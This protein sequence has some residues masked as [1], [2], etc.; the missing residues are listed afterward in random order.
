MIGLLWF[1]GILSK[2]FNGNGFSLQIQFKALHSSI[3]WLILLSVFSMYMYLLG[4]KV[5]W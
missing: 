2:S 3:L 1:V 5:I 4:N